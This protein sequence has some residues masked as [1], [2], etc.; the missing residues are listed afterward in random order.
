[1]QTKTDSMAWS[2]LS[3][4]AA[5]LQQLVGFLHKQSRT[6]DVQKKQVIMELRD[7][8]NLFK[9]ALQLPISYD[10][11]IDLLSN[12]AYRNAVKENFA[13]KKL[14]G[15]K[16]ERKHI[17]EERNLRYEGW[18]AEKLMDKIDE[19]IQSLKNFKK[20]HGG[21]V[22]KAGTRA[23]LKVSNLYYRMKLMADFLYRE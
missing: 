15:G 2:W 5:P 14:K 13:F 11:L 12:E 4:T 20:L 21:S 6:N 23:S 10:Q 18:T 16:I 9:E 1:M 17:L 8:L 19:K 22:E 3:S 7:N